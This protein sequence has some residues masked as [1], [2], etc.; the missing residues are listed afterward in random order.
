MTRTLPHIGSGQYVHRDARG[1]A[2]ITM[3]RCDQPSAPLDSR[4]V[5]G[6]RI[7]LVD[8]TSVRDEMA[9]CI[10]LIRP[11]GVGGVDWLAMEPCTSMHLPTP[12][13]PLAVIAARTR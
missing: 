1:G 2:S 9:N 8:D 4:K 11:L 7:D 6:S 10:V 5:C 3:I 12:F 13:P